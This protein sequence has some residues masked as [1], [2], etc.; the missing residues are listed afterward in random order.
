MPVWTSR[1]KLTSATFGVELYLLSMVAAIRREVVIEPG[2]VVRIVAPELSP[3]TRAEV[4]ILVDSPATNILHASI[5]A[6]AAARLKAFREFHASVSL[7]DA[8]VAAWQQR[9][10][11]ERKAYSLKSESRWGEQQSGGT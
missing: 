6:D 3:G 8:E 4:I 10:A 1:L 2:G 5:S 9:N 11:E 7:T